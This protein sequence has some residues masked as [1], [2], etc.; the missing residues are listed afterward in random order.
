MPAMTAT[1][2]AELISDVEAAVSGGSPERRVLMLRR[3]IQLLVSSAA[4]L[5][6]T[7]LGVFDDVLVRLIKHVKPQALV[8]PTPPPPDLTPAPKGAVR[9]PACH[10]DIAVATPVLIR[11]HSLSDTVL[12]EIASK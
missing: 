2:S 12:V 9:S 11:S 8:H 3:L 5:N 7:Q 10:N 6:E 1:A 4:R